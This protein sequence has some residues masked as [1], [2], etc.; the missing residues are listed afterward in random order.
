MTWQAMSDSD[1]SLA[2]YIGQFS[3]ALFERGMISSTNSVPADEW[4]TVGADV[5]RATIFSNWQQAIDTQCGAWVNPALVDFSGGSSLPS[6]QWTIEALRAAAGLHPDGWLRK[7]PREFDA[8]ATHPPGTA[9]M[10]ARG[11]GRIYVHDGTQWNLGD[12]TLMPD[13]LTAY[14]RMQVGDYIGLHIFTELENM[15]QALGNVKNE[16]VNSG[17]VMSSAEYKSIQMTWNKEAYSLEE[18]IAAGTAAW[19]TA[20]NDG[21]IIPIPM[22]HAS[23]QERSDQ[24]CTVASHCR[25]LM[26]K[27]PDRQ[28]EVWT[29]ARKSR[30]VQL[31]GT[32]GSATPG[33]FGTQVWDAV[34]ENVIEDGWT[35]MFA[36]DGEDDVW[37]GQSPLSD[38]PDWPS[39]MNSQRG[40][41]VSGIRV[42]MTLDYQLWPYGV[43]IP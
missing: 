26:P 13:T 12:Q 19:D 22:M 30:V 38:R 9:G 39:T 29:F 33:F 21:S 11:S 40:H 16:N 5:Q 10:V 8:S 34:N 41:E 36:G 6:F 25:G 42:M 15:I 17:T 14:G 23:I 4:P 35:M 20:G 37:I 3:R 43:P 32:D 18:A 28:I 1:W 27:F 7:Y 24:W 31:S 2:S